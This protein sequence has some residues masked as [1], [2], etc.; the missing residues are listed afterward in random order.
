MELVERVMAGAGCLGHIRRAR[1]MADGDVDQ[2]VPAV[3]THCRNEEVR[4]LSIIVVCDSEDS[5]LPVVNSQA[6]RVRQ[7]FDLRLDGVVSVCAQV[8]ELRTGPEVTRIGPVNDLV[9]PAA[10]SGGQLVEGHAQS[11]TTAFA[12]SLSCDDGLVILRHGEEPRTSEGAVVAE[13]TRFVS[14]GSMRCNVLF[15]LA[16]TM[17]G[18]DLGEKELKLSCLEVGRKCARDVDSSGVCG[19][20]DLAVVGSDSARFASR[21]L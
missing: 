10:A 9:S 2:E 5:E 15:E 6:R 21:E 14:R 13:D 8:F 11:Q 17:R 19:V 18:E 7:C 3:F 20:F 12:E 1:W 4:S 16:D